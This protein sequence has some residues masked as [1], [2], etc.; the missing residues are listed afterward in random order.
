MQPLRLTL[1]PLVG[2][3]W[4]RHIKSGANLRGN[5]PL[6][7]ARVSLDGLALALGG[8]VKPLAQ[9]NDKSL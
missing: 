9:E 1:H 2:V 6:Q 7:Y 4:T 8:Q 5:A 3:H